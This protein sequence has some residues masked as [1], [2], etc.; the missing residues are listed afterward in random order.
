MARACDGHYNRCVKLARN[1]PEYALRLPLDHVGI[2]VPSIAA[3]LPF[4]EML[5]GGSSTPIEHVESQGVAVVFVGDETRIELIQP[6]RPDST[7]QRFLDRRGAGLHHLAYRVD[8]IRREL[9]RLRAAG[10]RLIDEEPRPG[11]EGHLVAFLHPSASGG[12][13]VELVQ[14]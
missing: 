3:A 14:R 13:L 9:D 4:Y 5:T 12:V 1:R 11:A 2:A 6:S 7:V 10:V 8:D